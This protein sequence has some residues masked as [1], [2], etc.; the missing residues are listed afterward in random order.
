MLILVQKDT[1]RSTFLDEI[2]TRAG[3]RYG[4]GSDYLVG[5]D[6]K[7]FRLTFDCKNCQMKV[8]G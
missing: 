1:E 3:I 5:T 2:G 7:R 8:S 4:T 6:G